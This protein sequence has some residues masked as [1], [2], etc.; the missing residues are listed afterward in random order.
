MAPPTAAVVARKSR[1]L[2][3]KVVLVS[4]FAVMIHP[5]L[6][7][8]LGRARRQVEAKNHGPA[9]GGGGGQEV[10]ATG[11]KG[12]AGLKVRGHDPSLP[13]PASRPSSAAGR[14]QEPWP[15]QRRRWWPG[16]LGDWVQRSCWS[17]GS[18]S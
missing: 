12:R 6:R 5:S 11:F 17:Q 8:H 2:G 14:S 18:R 1:R 10:S 3:S 9:N 13:T 15:R 7:L 16:S 4:R